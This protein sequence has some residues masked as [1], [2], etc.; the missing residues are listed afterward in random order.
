MFD[1]Y[2]I[3]VDRRELRRRAKLVKVEPQ[4]FDVLVFLIQHRHMVVTRKQ[5]LNAVWQGRIISNSTLASRIAAAR[6]A[7]GDTGRRQR[8]IRTFSRKGLRFVAGVT[9]MPRLALAMPEGATTSTDQHN[10]S[11]TSGKIRLMV[12]PFSVEGDNVQTASF[13][14]G[15]CE[16]IIAA[17]SR[18]ARIEVS[19]PSNR[20]SDLTETAGVASQKPDYTLTAF[21]ARTSDRV[22]LLGRL[23]AEDS[24]VIWAERFE[25]RLDE[26][27]SLRDEFTNRVLASTTHQVGAMEIT[28]ATRKRPESLL[29][30]DLY[31]RALGS[32]RSMTRVGSDTALKL[33]AN[34]ME[35]D[36][37]Y[38]AAA[39]LSAW[40]RTLR[41]AQNWTDDADF[42]ERV[43]LEHGRIAISSGA[44]DAVALATGA[45]ALAALGGEFRDSLPAIE[46]AIDREPSNSIVLT[47]AGWIYNY[48]GEHER[49]AG[50]LESAIKLGTA[51][52]TL[53]RAHTALAYA[54]LVRGD[55]DAAEVSARAAVTANPNYTVAYRAHASALANGGRTNAAKAVMRRLCVITPRLSERTLAEVSVFRRSGGLD[56]I[57]SGLRTAGIPK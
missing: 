26:T 57:L 2:T 28:K 56:R 13:A 43:G 45:Y 8:C 4:V 39:G 1:T 34:A 27:F 40:A 5:L 41:V 17:I 38:G 48:L 18:I 54:Q 33:L 46:R 53:F 49:A 22:R 21:V 50:Y 51:D 31:L 42:E 32:V 37:N 29:A 3:D 23:V 25:G 36:P 55:F 35:I 9:E 10:V 44:D 19:I 11:P 16:E 30:Y 24:T 7:I 12:L 15:V 6:S 52:P 14:R 20:L 47:H